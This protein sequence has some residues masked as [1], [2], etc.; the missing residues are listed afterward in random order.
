MNH[1]ERTVRIR[2]I[3]RFLTNKVRYSNDE[4]YAAIVMLDQIRLE[5]SG[6]HL[7][8]LEQIEKDISRLTERIAMGLHFST[9]TI[10]K[11]AMLSAR[12][13][14][15]SE[16]QGNRCNNTC[17]ALKNRYAYAV[18]LL[19]SSALSQALLNNGYSQSQADLLPEDWEPG[20]GS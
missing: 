16:C 1:K 19:E 10:A 4:I 7:T 2:T 9:D 17:P 15:C 3:G 5:S 14:W 18:A 13:S 8:Q 12:T 20:K 6:I 11:T